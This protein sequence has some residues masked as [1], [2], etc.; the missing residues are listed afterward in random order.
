MQP[1]QLQLSHSFSKA[2]LMSSDFRDSLIALLPS[3]RRDEPAGLRQEIFDELNDH[4]TCSIHRELLRGLDSTAARARALE[5]FGDPAAVARRLWLDAMKG[6]IMAQRVLIGTCVLVAA[7]SLALVGMFW[8]FAVHAQRAVAAQRAEAAAREQ[9]MLKQLKAMSE[10]VRNPRS[11]DWNPL[12]IRLTENTLDGP[13]VP[14]VNV[15]LERVHS[16][17]GGGVYGRYLKSDPSGIVD[18]G[19]VNPGEYNFSLFQLATGAQGISRRASVQVS[20]QP[21][22]DVTKHIVCPKTPAETAPVTIKC[23]WPADLEKEDLRVFISFEFQARRFSDLVWHLGLTHGLLVGPASQPVQ[24]LRGRRPLLCRAGGQP[25]LSAE[26]LNAYIRH[27]DESSGEFDW[28]LGFYRIESMIVLRPTNDQSP[29]WKRY[30]VIAGSRAP[31]PVTSLQQRSLFPDTWDGFLIH[32]EPPKGVQPDPKPAQAGNGNS[33]RHERVGP[34]EWIPQPSGPQVSNYS[35]SRIEHPLEIRSGR[36]NEWTV[37]LPDELIA[38]VRNQ[39]KSHK[40]SEPR[41]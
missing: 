20:V 37:S 3:P 15:A 35:W 13:P 8:Q 9:E 31:Q 21:G 16:G 25:E 36:I 29:T 30:Q 40:P 12:K 6:K 34:L 38:F 28:E 7:A 18:F 23:S 10:A 1:E 11:L 2:F 19:L 22:N 24:I 5:R 17:N 4:L 33:G 14:G 32:D 27:S 39:Q 26:V 41:K